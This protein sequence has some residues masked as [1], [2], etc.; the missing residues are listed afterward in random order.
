VNPDVIVVGGGAVGASIS[1]QLAKAGARVALLERG[2]IGAEATGASAGMLIAHHGRGT[3]E[4]FARLSEESARL[5]P[6]LAEELRE[7]IGADIGFRPL[8]MLEVALDET[9]EQEL[10][11]E[12]AWEADHGV[13]VRWLDP[14]AAL[15]IEPALN[16][17]VRGATYYTADHQL[18]PRQFAEAMARAAAELG[19]DIREG[20]AVDRLLVEGDRVAG[21]GFGMESLRA[22]ET[23]LATGSWS[24]AWGRDLNASIPVRPIRGQMVALQRYGSGLRTVISG[25]NGYVVAKPDGRMIAGTTVEDVG[26]EGRPT[27][28]GISSILARIP[29]LSPRLS[30]ATVT[31]VWAGL[32]PGTPD[33]LPILGRV[34]PWR[35]VTLATGHF[36]NGI[37][38]APITA[39]LIGDLL[40]RRSPRFDLTPYDPA[41]FLVRAA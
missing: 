14:G 30:N 25:A 39:E 28:D 2:A 21:V 8:T 19:A 16:P 10:R 37:L 36:R 22:D 11:R 34:A 5:F 26:F 32:R 4:P 9:E 38:L 35:G 15:D 13:S 41:R 18:L 27:V 40:Q 12:R 29:R 33:G 20:V 24:H 23:V 17:A 31:A 7:R 6:A 3:P 1:L